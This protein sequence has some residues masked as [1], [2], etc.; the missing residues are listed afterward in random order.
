MEG[1]NVVKSLAAKK[2]K[3]ND[4]KAIVARCALG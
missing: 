2:R 1:K 4:S 3:M